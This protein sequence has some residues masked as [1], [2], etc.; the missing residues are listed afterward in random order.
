MLAASLR[1]ST[2]RSNEMNTTRPIVFVVDDDVS[3]RESLELLLASAGF[4]AELFVAAQDFLKRDRPDVPH[5]M[6]LD[7]SLPGLNGLE[8]QKRLAGER[9]EMPIIFI[10]GYGDI[11]TSV[12]AMKGGAVE[13]LTKPFVDDVLL[14]AVHASLSRS[15]ILLQRETEVLELRRRYDQLTAR[16]REVM[17]LVVAGLANKQVG[18]ELGITE[19]TV[20]AHRGSAVRKMQAKSLADLVKMSGRLRIRLPRDPSRVSKDRGGTP[21]S[22][23]APIKI[24][25]IEDHPIFRD[26]LSTMFGSQMDLLLVGQAA[27]AGEGIEQFCKLRPDIVLLDLSLPDDNG[28]NVLRT[29]LSIAATAKVIILTTFDSETDISSALSGGAAGYIPKSMPREQILAKIRSI[30]HGE[31]G[32]GNARRESD[33]QGQD[34]SLV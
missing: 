13:F 28:L 3:I 2:D 10:T 20:K 4:D 7:I 24:L 22:M 14:K 33:P 27:T 30:H 15:E 23:P 8:L 34:Q 1:V 32:P 18:S 11:P 25:S 21:A 19:I 31:N 17:A 9:P 16:E 6:I 29:L 26:G 12:Q 5:C